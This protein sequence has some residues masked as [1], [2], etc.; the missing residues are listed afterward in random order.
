M[1]NLPPADHTPLHHPPL[2]LVVAQARFSSPVQEVTQDLV[3]RLQRGLLE[4]GYHFDRV[5]SV[6]MSEVFLGPG[7]RPASSDRVTGVQLTSH[8]RSWMVTLMPASVSLETPSFSS[9]AGQFG[10]LLGHVLRLVTDVV[11][12]LTLTRAGLRF[13][14][15]LRRPDDAGGWERWVRSFLL[16][17]HNDD[18]IGMGVVS[19]SQQLLLDVATGVRSAVQAGSAEIDGDEGFLLDIDTFTEPSTLWAL[20]DVMF[21]FELLN[22]SGVAL[23]QVL[24]TPEMLTRLSSGDDEVEAGRDD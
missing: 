15:V 20:E 13:V 16:A 4:A 21:G 22:R 24:V 11:R 8:D 2:P 12:P 14:N 23:F 10:P 3:A 7:Q 5:A 19:Q 9:F 18:L 6:E 17:A 1:L